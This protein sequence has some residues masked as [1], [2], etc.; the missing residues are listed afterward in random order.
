MLGL[1]IFSVL[2][3]K[4]RMLFID[5]A[6]LTF[7]IVNTKWF[8]FSEH[9]YGAWFTQSF[10]MIGSWLGLSLKGILMLYS[11]SFYL[12]YSAVMWIVGNRWRQ[13]GLATLL[14]CYN[15]LLVSDVFFWP[16]NEVHQGIAWLILWIGYFR[17]LSHRGDTISRLEH[18]FL[19]ALLCCC[20][21]SHL[22]VL[23]PLGFLWAYLMI[24]DGRLAKLRELSTE[25]CYSILIGL[26]AYI[27]YSISRSTYYDKQKLSNLDTISLSSISD[28]FQNGHAETVSSLLIQDY[29]LFIVLGLMSI[30][31]LMYSRR[32]L[33]LTLTSI[34]S[35]VYCYLILLTFPDAFDRS[36]LFYMESE[37]MCLSLIVVSPLLLTLVYKVKH[38]SIALGVLLLVMG[39]G[40]MAIQDSNQLFT[41]RLD[42]LTSLTEA[43]H[44]QS[45]TK[46]L[47]RNQDHDSGWIMQWGL[48]IESLILSN[49]EG[50]AEQ[51][52]FKLYAG[53]TIPTLDSSIF[54]TPFKEIPIAQLNSN[55]FTLDSVSTYQ[56]LEVD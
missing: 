35:L 7:E 28:T 8:V 22:L 15:I 12:L 38:Q 24:A 31:G 4:Q 48:P 50:Y 29:Q 44:Q 46:T 42:K 6:F 40:Y 53:D 32:W 19:V 17:K 34:S 27:K 21:S 30:I 11:A 36:L 9:R 43:I 16:N 45:G 51:V 56:L 37:W 49:L 55:Y 54:L 47:L 52:S 5:P 10:P 33:L 20:I 13:Y 39:S 41:H 26:L 1:L 18:G 3:Y 23:I 2:Y 25:W 14:F